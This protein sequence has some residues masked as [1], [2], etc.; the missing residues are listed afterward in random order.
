MLQTRAPGHGAASWADDLDEWNERFPGLG[1]S[2]TDLPGASAGDVL[3]A[4]CPAPLLVMSTGRGTLLH[5]SLDGPHRWLLRH[6]TSPMALVPQVH[7]P[8]R[9][10]REEV[11]AVG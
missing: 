1:V 3:S 2:R 7:R 8:D 4:A 5:R 9:E 11:N 10:A 6:C